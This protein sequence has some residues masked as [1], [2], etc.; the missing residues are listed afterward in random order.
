MILFAILMLAVFGKLIGFA[1]RAEWGLTKVFFG[2]IFLPAILIV[3]V[4][5]GLICV[6]WPIL[7][8]VG[9]VLLIKRFVGTSEYEH[10][11]Y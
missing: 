4:I 6:V 1:F 3:M 5:V 7:A 2:L 9:L 10:M 8:I 11:V